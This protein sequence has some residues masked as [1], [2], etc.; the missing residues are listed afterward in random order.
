MEGSW[1]VETGL[2]SAHGRA[3]VLQAR[4]S[5][6]GGRLLFYKSSFF[7]RSSE[8]FANYA[9]IPSNPPYASCSAA[10]PIIPKHKSVPTNHNPLRA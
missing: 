5:E 7:P 2:Q 3:A 8:D 9:Q 1:T 4:K 6:E 10:R